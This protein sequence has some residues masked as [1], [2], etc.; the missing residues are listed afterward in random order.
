MILGMVPMET[1]TEQ[2]S[3]TNTKKD[4]RLM[5]RTDGTRIP[6]RGSTH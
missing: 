1:E 6:P 5:R 4:P 2:K 3:N